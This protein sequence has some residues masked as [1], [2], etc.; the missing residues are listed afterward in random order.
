MCGP[1]FANGARLAAWRKILSTPSGKAGTW[2]RS[3]WNAPRRT[4][5]A[6]LRMPSAGRR[7]LAFDLGAESGRAILGELRSGVLD[8][9]EVSRFRNEP[10]H[11]NGSL[12]WNILRL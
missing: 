5:L 3:R 10:V 1:R 12:R 4:L 7:Y 2:R 6:S 9:R 8:I 11:E